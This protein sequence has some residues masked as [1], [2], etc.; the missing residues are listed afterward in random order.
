M[1]VSIIPAT[2]ILELSYAHPNPTLAAA[3]LNAIANAVVVEGAESIR[4]QATSVRSF[5]EDKIPEQQAK[6]QAL[7]DAE[8]QYRQETGIVSLDVQ[9]EQLI[10]SLTDVQTQERGLVTQLQDTR[11]RGS[12]LQS[13]TGINNLDRAY[14][15]VRAGQN[16]SIRQ[17]EANLV[18]VEAL[19]G[20]T[21]PL[22]GSNHPDM[23][24]LAARRDEARSLYRQSLSTFMPGLDVLSS[25]SQR[26]GQNASEKVSQDLVIEYITGRIEQDAL[27]E[28]LATVQAEKSQLEGDL[29]LIPQYQ[30][31]LA[32]LVRDRSITSVWDFA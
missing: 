28:V 21:E 22:L 26:L 3:L 25:L 20:E 14:K 19:V 10:S 7:A 11:V 1:T 9:T 15:T 27:A 17:I 24:A 6:L 30:Q 23:V 4:S 12:M 31:P 29:A 18:E 13:V 32:T 16:D 2:N 8:M 5:L